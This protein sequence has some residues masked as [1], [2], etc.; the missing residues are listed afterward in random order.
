MPRPILA[1]IHMGSLR[2]NL[3]RMREAAG[4]RTLWAVVK[5]NAY[6]HGMVMV[7][8]ELNRMGVRAFCVASV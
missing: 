2:H 8:E 5:A 1:T 3:E 6:G 4:Q 7:A